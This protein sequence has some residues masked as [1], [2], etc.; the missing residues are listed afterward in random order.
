MNKIEFLK[1]L[2]AEVPD[3]SGKSKPK[4]GKSD[5]KKEGKKPFPPKG[6]SDKESAPEENGGGKEFPFKKAKPANGEDEGANAE[7]QGSEGGEQE[8]P[9]NE[10]AEGAVVPG[11]SADPT[12]IID[13]FAQNP[14]PDDEAYHEFAEQQGFDVHSAEQIAY[15]LAGKYVMLLRGGKSLDADMSSVDPQQLEMGMQ[16]E[17]EHTDDPA[18]QKKIS[19]DHLVEMPDY[20]SKLQQMEGGGDQAA[21]QEQPP[22]QNQ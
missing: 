17:S 6:K 1:K 15:A 2:A 20:Y 19:F 18:T 14:N 8:I 9:G 12:A 3:E 10:S 22:V 21:Q 5:S 16:V 13:F 4:E 7:T 11:G